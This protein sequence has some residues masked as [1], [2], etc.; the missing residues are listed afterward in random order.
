MSN[1]KD[2]I[3][4]ISSLKE[5]EKIPV[6]IPSLGKT[7]DFKPINVRQQKNLLKETIGGVSSISELLIQFN[8]IILDNINDDSEDLLCLDKYPVLV[9]LRKN[10]FGDKINIKGKEYSLNDLQPPCKVTG[11]ISNKEIDFKTIKVFLKTPTIKE[12]NQFLA[13]QSNEIKKKNIDD[14]KDVISAL[15]V[16]EIAKFVESISI[17]DTQ[18]SFANLS[19][20][21]RIAI[22]ESLPISLNQKILNFISKV[23]EFENKFITFDDGTTLPIDALFVTTD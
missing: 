7:K 15:Y 11:N 22:I 12:E 8:T 4:R 21:E 19:I 5:E 13:K 20:N 6:L 18:V 1:V 9:E 23:R 16:F 14:G 2:L 3:S 10:A 17:E